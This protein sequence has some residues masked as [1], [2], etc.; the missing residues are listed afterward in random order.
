MSFCR[1][2]RCPW[3]FFC[4]HV[5]NCSEDE[6]KGGESAVFKSST[7]MRT[8]MKRAKQPRRQSNRIEQ[9]RGEAAAKTRCCLHTHG[10]T[11]HQPSACA[12]CDWYV[13]VGLFAP[14]HSFIM[15]VFTFALSS[16]SSQEIV[17]S[18]NFPY[19]LSPFNVG[20]KG[21]SCKNCLAQGPSVS[22]GLLLFAG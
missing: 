15:R 8:H 22:V 7:H 18:D 20:I 6:R 4:T 11:P 19:R 14:R 13:S 5:K 12:A 21:S 2:F 10:V 17:E 3:R 1:P 9:R 16:Q